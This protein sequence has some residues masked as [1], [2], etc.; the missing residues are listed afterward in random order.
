MSIQSRYRVT[1][2][3]RERLLVPLSILPVSVP[4]HK[5]FPFFAT[6]ED[7][8][9]DPSKPEVSLLFL[10]RFGRPVTGVLSPLAIG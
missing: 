9:F 4:W 2:A 10:R 8:H 6:P 7:R 5:A 1:R 3:C